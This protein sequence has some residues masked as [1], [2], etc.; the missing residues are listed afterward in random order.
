MPAKADSACHGCKRR[1]IGC[2]ADCPDYAAY[3]VENEERLEKLRAY[4]AQKNMLRDLKNTSQIKRLR[5]VISKR[6]KT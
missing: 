3:R 2:H 1:A 5:R 6:T 4:N